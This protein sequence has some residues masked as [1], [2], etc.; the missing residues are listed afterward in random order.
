MSPPAWLGAAAA[1]RFSELAPAM[2][3]AASRL[4]RDWPKEHRPAPLA[5]WSDHQEKG[6][7]D[8]V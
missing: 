6:E 1:A 7:L 2:Q 4:P 8:D 5:G 3:D